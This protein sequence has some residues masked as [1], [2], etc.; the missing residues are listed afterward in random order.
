MTIKSLNNNNL[1]YL[2]LGL[3]VFFLYISYEN[4]DINYIGKLF[5]ISQKNIG[6]ISIYSILLLFL[7]RSFSIVIPIIPGTYC[8]VLAGYTYGIRYGLLLIGIADFLSCSVSFFI[9]R[10]FGRDFVS[11]FL[12]QRQMKKIEIISQKYLEN[13][14]FLM[15][16]FLLTS[17]FDFVCYAVGLTKISWKKFMP[18]LVLS[19]IISDLPFVSAGYAL[20]SLR[21][22]NLQMILAGEVSGISGNS[23]L[24]LIT[25]ALLI[26]GLGFLNIFMKNKNKA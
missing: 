11:R 4:F 21:N 10:R 20:R 25:T 19:I 22:I 3:I 15:T 13:N 14:F 24:L 8:S 16:G 23:L 9:S 5:E 1:K 17:W 26:F 12:G 6:S 2:Y 7:L 18:A